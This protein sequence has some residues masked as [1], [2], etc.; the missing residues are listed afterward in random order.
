M[1]WTSADWKFEKNKKFVFFFF[2][3]FRFV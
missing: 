3:G 1:I 2:I